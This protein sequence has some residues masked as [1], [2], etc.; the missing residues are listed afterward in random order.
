MWHDI[1]HVFIPCQS[2]CGWTQGVKDTLGGQVKR[3]TVVYLYDLCSYCTGRYSTVST[4]CTGA[5]PV[6]RPSSG[7]PIFVR[8]VRLSSGV[9]GFRS[10]CPAFVR[11]SSGF[12]Q[13]SSVRQ[14]IRYRLFRLHSNFELHSCKRRTNKQCLSTS[15]SLI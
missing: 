13:V 8:L 11:P 4:V 6:V 5:C 2:L 7:R 12:R 14:P 15:T 9:S 10:A 3:S 1:D